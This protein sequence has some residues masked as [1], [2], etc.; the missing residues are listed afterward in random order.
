VGKKG[1]K[2]LE[3]KG[4]KKIIPLFTNTSVVMALFSPS[5]LLNEEK[6]FL[7]ILLRSQLKK[8]S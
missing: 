8:Y 4:R 3:A 6:S 1:G 5:N 7:L 2:D